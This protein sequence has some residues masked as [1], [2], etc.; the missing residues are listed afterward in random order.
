MDQ[1][2]KTFK[3]IILFL[4]MLLA[5]MP[6]AMASCESGTNEFAEA[7]SEVASELE[8]LKSGST[9]VPSVT[10]R[11]EDVSESMMAAYAEKLRDF[12]YVIAGSGKSE[13]GKSVVVTVNITT[14]DFGS[15]YLETW[16]DRMK[17]EEDL[18]YDSQ[19]Y[20][21][22]FTRFA[23]LSVKNYTGQAAIV[24]TKGGDGKWTTDVKTNPDLINAI[25]GGLVAEMTDLAEESSEGS[26]DK[27]ADGSAEE[28]AD[29]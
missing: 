14:Y 26:E 10:E 28:E 11:S 8:A 18:R 23:A 27:S 20:S 5:F 9:E 19:F 6:V 21:D 16:N 25:S 12:D 29:E 2:G 7:E 17:I 3:P 13:D 4:M 15:V 1:K 24:C 22:L